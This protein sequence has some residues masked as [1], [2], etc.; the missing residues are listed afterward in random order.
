MY[1]IILLN[2]MYTTDTA[3]EILRVRLDK[4]ANIICTNYTTLIDALYAKK[5]IAIETKDDI[6]LRNSETDY[7]KASKLLLVIERNLVA[8]GVPN[9]YLIEFCH[10]LME[11]RHQTLTIIACAIL[12]QLGKHKVAIIV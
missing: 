7:K 8:S 3:R 1:I 11:Q 2:I 10:V 9:K 4:L 12:H 5:L 6:Q